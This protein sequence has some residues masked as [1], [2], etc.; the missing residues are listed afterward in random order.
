MKYFISIFF[1]VF[2]LQ[3][4]VAQ[5]FQ[6]SFNYCDGPPNVNDESAEYIAE[7]EDGYLIFAQNLYANFCVLKLDFAGELIDARN[8]DFTPN[9][10]Q[11][12]S[13]GLVKDDA[14]NFYIVGRTDSGPGD[15]DV[16][17][18]KISGITLDTLWTKKYLFDEYQ[19]GN[20]IKFTAE[21]KLTIMA[22][23]DSLDLNTG[24]VKKNDFLFLE[25]DTLGNL[26]DTFLLSEDE[27]IDLG[28]F[29][30]LPSGEFI[31]VYGTEIDIDEY[32][33]YKCLLN[34]KYQKI[35][36]DT[37]SSTL[38]GYTTEPELAVSPDS[39]VIYVAWKRENPFWASERPNSSVVV[40][41]LTKENELLWERVLWFGESDV[42][43][44][45][46]TE[47]GSIIG[48]GGGLN[49]T[50]IRSDWKGRVFKFQPNGDLDFYHLFHF[51]N[52]LL[53]EYDEENPSF[54]WDIIET[55]DGGFLSVGQ[56]RPPGWNVIDSTNRSNIYVVKT[57][58]N[59]CF[60]PICDSLV[61]DISGLS[62]S[63]EVFINEFEIY[64]NPTSET[65]NITF[66]PSL[67][68]V[69]FSLFSLTGKKVLQ[70]NEL[71]SGSQINIADLP[72]G[73]YFYQLQ[74]ADNQ[75]VGSG[76]VVV[77]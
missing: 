28:D 31:I 71:W 30:P 19:I 8:F 47:D 63:K 4:L 62:S 50:S 25:I 11:S 65:I 44:L 67:D 24:F 16:Y 45:K 20:S 75:R 59:G 61:I 70:K 48:S 10:F 35:W 51:D 60:S 73:I 77:Q 76:R 23:T 58:E 43:S 39:S 36:C 9:F 68:K 69:N 34:S 49:N 42:T 41:A 72:K 55:S 13:N 46:V 7:V 6:K 38:K 5:T 22:E 15:S 29:H 40:Q 64:P 12:R 26:L 33:G 18:M 32:F 1:S 21:N 57:N 37:I 74:N 53:K 52:E 3:I 56:I 2:C 17:L 14:D 54:L 66:N 27:S